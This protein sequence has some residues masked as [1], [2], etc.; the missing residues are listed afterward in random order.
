MSIKALEESLKAVVGIPT[1]DIGATTVDGY[2]VSTKDYD[3]ALVV[4]N[5]ATTDGTMDIKLQESSDDGVGD[6]YTDIA[7]A[8]FEQITP[9]NDN[10]VYVGRVRVKNF[11]D[12]L[13]VSATGTGTTTVVGATIL[14]GKFDGLAPVSQE[15]AV[16]FAIDYVANGG[17]PSV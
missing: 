13:R 9:A 17:T 16:A 11:E 5:V 8:V 3:E 1:Q 14:L 6:A 10:T 4:V 12:F 7:G 2:G 15:N